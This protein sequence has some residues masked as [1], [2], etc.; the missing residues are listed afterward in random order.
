[1]VIFIGLHLFVNISGKAI[2]SKKLE[3]A[4]DGKVKIESLSTSLPLNF[5]AR[6]VEIEG[7]GKIKEVI[8]GAGIFDI[9]RK[10][11]K[12]S[13]VQIISP[14]F[15]FSNN[16]FSALA[17]T[18]IFGSSQVLGAGSADTPAQDQAQ[19]KD[20]PVI[21]LKTA[22]PAIEKAPK[23]YIKRLLV[24]SGSFTIVDRQ[25]DGKEIT[26]SVDGLDINVG[27]LKFTNIGYVVSNF[28]IKGNIPWND[29]KGDRGSIQAKGW[30]DYVNR[31]MQASLN[32][33][34]IDAVSL[35]PYYSNWVD[36][37]KARIEKAKL[38][39][40]SDIQGLNNNI[41]ADC[42][43]ELTEIV[44][45]PLK[46]GEEQ[47]KASKI[48]DAV[49]D[50]FR[51]MN[52][53]NIVLNFTIRTKMDRPEFGFEDIR[54]AFEDKMSQRKRS[55]LP[56]NLVK[57]PV[58]LLHGT[59]KAATDLTRAVVEGVISVGKEIKN[60]TEGAFSKDG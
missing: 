59:F 15:K 8:F 13:R 16:P 51:A 29:N 42:R 43:L 25:K 49:L 60:S 11:F 27:N 31:S 44:R 50:I 18:R 19:N 52:G 33:K 57:L 36:L 7:L 4:F 1:M 6:N 54:T 24:R 41:V 30:F 40:S 5:H 26:V 28:D 38:N 56:Q 3:K 12:L 32:I 2:L 37:D 14:S 48:T 46:E 47:Q 22:G 55:S 53:G 34:D 58:T 21:D 10:D 9:Y 20:I 35:Y 17:Q 23:F 39:F 45:R